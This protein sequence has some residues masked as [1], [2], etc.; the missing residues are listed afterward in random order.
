[1]LDAFTHCERLSKRPSGEV[2]L[3]VGDVRLSPDL[4]IRAALGASPWDLVRLVVGSDA[5]P[6]VAGIVIGVGGARILESVLFQ[7]RPIDAPV[8]QSVRGKTRASRSA[9]THRKKGG[10]RTRESGRNCRDRFKS[11]ALA[12]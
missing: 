2:G 3:M 1:V 10:V 12:P 6:V 11:N 8:G 5:I 4:G 9:S 7:T